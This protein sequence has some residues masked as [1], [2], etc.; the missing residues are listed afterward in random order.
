M[1][2]VA[3]VRTKVTHKTTKKIARFQSD[4]FMRVKPSWRKPRGI[5]NPLRRHFKGRGAMP[6][7]GF[8]APNATRYMRKNRFIDFLVRNVQEVEALLL[9]NTK[10]QAVIA[11]SVSAA[12]R[13]QII[14]RA[15]ELNV[16]VANVRG[17]LKT[18]EQK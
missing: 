5:D 15:R 13:K 16:N 12:T 18:V 7:V 6:N 8:R 10:Y 2:A 14:E 17:K 11:S 1:P 4:K 9:Q 3:A